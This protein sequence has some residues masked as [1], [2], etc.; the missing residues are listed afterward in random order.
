NLRK[1]AAPARCQPMADGRS[2]QC[3]LTHASGETKAL[4]VFGRSA[5]PLERRLNAEIDKHRLYFS[6]TITIIAIK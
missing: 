6:N 4:R 2:A 3:A 1:C 5:L